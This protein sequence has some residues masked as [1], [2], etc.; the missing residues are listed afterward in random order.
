MRFLGLN[1]ISFTAEL[2]GR[3]RGRLLADFNN[4]SCHAH[5]L[6]VPAT[7]ALSGMNMHGSCNWGIM[8]GVDETAAK[9]LQAMYR[10]YRIGQKKTVRWTVVIQAASHSRVLERSCHTRHM[11]AVA[12]LS[13]LPIEITGDLRAIMCYEAAREQ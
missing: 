1:I 9:A 8:V 13:Q 6:V 2:Q 10:I 11:Q 7:M 4:G 5:A 3:E 12:V